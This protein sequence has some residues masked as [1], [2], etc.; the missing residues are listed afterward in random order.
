M[1]P[2]TLVMYYV[3][4]MISCFGFWY[5]RSKNNNSPGEPVRGSDGMMYHSL[6]RVL[7]LSLAFF[8]GSGITSLLSILLDFIGCSACFENIKIDFLF[9]TGLAF[10]FVVIIP[11]DIVYLK[12]INLVFAFFLGC[13]LSYLLTLL[14]R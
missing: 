8:L 9:S 11:Q 12:K 14:S 13:I 4:L 1:N 3:V 6:P 7:R 2:E 10:L 5:I